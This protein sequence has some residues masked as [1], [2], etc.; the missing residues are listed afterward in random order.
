[1][2]RV[3]YMT[4]VYSHRIVRKQ[5]VQAGEQIAAPNLSGNGQAAGIE[6]LEKAGISAEQ[7]DSAYQ[8][9]F[10]RS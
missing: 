2:K 1:M 3:R 4:P 9:L 8:Q 6:V 10:D 7:W 5:G